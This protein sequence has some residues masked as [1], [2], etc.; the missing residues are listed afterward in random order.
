VLSL[1]LHLAVEGQSRRQALHVQVH[2]RL[3]GSR[4]A[5]GGS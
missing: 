4:R 5:A 3:L 2:A 1:A